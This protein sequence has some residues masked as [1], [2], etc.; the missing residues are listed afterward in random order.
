[1]SNSVWPH[2]LYPARLLCP[3]DSQAG[4]LEWVAIPF[5]RGSSRPKDQTEVST[6]GRRILYHWDSWEAHKKGYLFLNFGQKWLSFP[7]GKIGWLKMPNKT[8]LFKR[9]LQLAIVF[10]PIA[11]TKF[12]KLIILPSRFR[13]SIYSCIHVINLDIYSLLIWKI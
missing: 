9:S 11:V 2:G 13:H 3:W 1:M 12:W 8:R 7:E 5:S 4:I 6:T 10:I